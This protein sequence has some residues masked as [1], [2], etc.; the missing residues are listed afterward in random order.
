MTPLIEILGPD[1]WYKL[2]PHPNISISPKSTVYNIKH[3]EQK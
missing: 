2:I 3:K 1:Q